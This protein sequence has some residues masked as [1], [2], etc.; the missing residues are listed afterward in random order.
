MSSHLVLT[1]SRL[2]EFEFGELPKGA[3]LKIAMNPYNGNVFLDVEKH[4]TST[5]IGLQLM[6]EIVEVCDVL[7]ELGADDPLREFVE[8]SDRGALNRK[9]AEA[10]RALIMVEKGGAEGKDLVGLSGE[11][12]RTA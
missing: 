6:R 5:V 2:S 12:E 7:E 11:K 8:L 3:M 10:A 9:L 4:E 1:Y